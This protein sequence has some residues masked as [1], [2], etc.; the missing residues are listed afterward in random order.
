[1][2][3]ANAPTQYSLKRSLLTQAE[4]RF[5]RTLCEA[6]QKAGADS[7]VGLMIATK[8]RIADVLTHP[9]YDKASLWRISQKH[10]D[11]ILCDA[12]TLQPLVA[13]ELDDRSHLEPNRQARDKFVNR[14]MAAARLPILH[15]PAKAQ[16]N[17]AELAEQ[18][19]QAMIIPGRG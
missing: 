8:V 16:Y 7:K 5:Y 13:V 11:F 2:D 14:A 18:I 19:R 15:I 9:F 17:A 12:E 6:S 10:I 3:L 4:L 1:M